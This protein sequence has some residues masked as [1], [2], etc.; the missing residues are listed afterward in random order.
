MA[1]SLPPIDEYVQISS[2]EIALLASFVTFW[3]IIYYRAVLSP[4]GRPDGFDTS[5]LISNLHACPLCIFAFLSLLHV[6]PESIPICWSIAFFLVDL[7]DAV[8]RRDAMFVVHAVL[9]LSLNL[10]TGG[11]ARHRAL[12]S[13]SKGMLAEASTPFLNYWKKSKSYTSFIIFFAVFTLCRILWIPYFVYSTY[14]IHLKG[15]IDFIIWPSVLFCIMQFLWY[16][17]MCKM[18]V[19]YRLP[20]DLEERL[21][22]AKEQ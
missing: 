13:S 12:M 8:V 15:E 6:I 16:F 21:N 19:K 11:T 2:P 4:A 18:V 20:K 3:V 7:V 17:K 9:S 5:A 10:F 1:S 14:A 22:R